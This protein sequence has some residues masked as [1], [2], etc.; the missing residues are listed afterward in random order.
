MWTSAFQQ[1]LRQRPDTEHQAGYIRI[2]I[3]AIASSY[4]AAIMLMGNLGSVDRAQV[5]GFVLFCDLYALGVMIHIVL[6]PQI[7]V[8]RRILS[9]VFDIGATTYGLYFLGESGV[10]IFGMLIFNPIGNGFRFGTRYLF[11]SC[12]LGMLGF[13]TVLLTSEYWMLHRTF[14]AGILIAMLVVPMYVASLIR[15]LHAA[16]SRLRTMATHDPLTGLPNR[17]A[18]YDVV[19]QTLTLAERKDSSFAIIFLDLDG[20]KPVNDTLGHAAGDEMLKLVAQ[21]LR[22][23]VRNSDVVA[24]IG[25]DEFVIIMPDIK[26]TSIPAIADQ[27][28]RAVAA[29]YVISGRTVTLTS[30]LGIATYPDGGRTVDAL[31]AQADSAM[32]KSKR[33]GGDRFC[34]DGDPRASGLMSNLT[35]PN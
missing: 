9:I 30:S 33:G 6:R 23:H 35:S 4:L 27:V 2:L 1:R 13:V 34:M 14:G 21:R 17:Q 11:F 29:P 3:A 8:P 12:A 25:G 15:D 28:I 5:A 16:L 10:P 7:C 32:Y 18:F 22:D 20:F 26:I 19:T 24:R 31:V